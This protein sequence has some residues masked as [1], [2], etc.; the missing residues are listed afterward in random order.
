MDIVKELAKSSTNLLAKNAK[1]TKIA[2][3]VAEISAKYA[4]KYTFT[5]IRSFPNQPPIITPTPGYIYY[6]WHPGYQKWWWTN[7]HDWEW[8]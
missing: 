7:G 8:L 2:D 4:A 6:Y 3:I 1:W 5:I